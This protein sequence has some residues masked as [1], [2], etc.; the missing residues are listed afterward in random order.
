MT[1]PARSAASL[2]LD[3]HSAV[4]ETGGDI[5]PQVFASIVSRLN[6]AGAVKAKI[7]GANE[8]TIDVTHLLVATTIE[9]TWLIEKLAAATGVPE[10]SVVFDLRKHIENV[11]G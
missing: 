10:E 7:S 9:L 3:L 2:L 6:S 11:A 1:T 4:A 5:D 8:V